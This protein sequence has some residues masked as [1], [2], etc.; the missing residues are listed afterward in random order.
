VERRAPAVAAG[1]ADNQGSE[2]D[3][4]AASF[5]V[6]VLSAFVSPATLHLAVT[7]EYL[8]APVLAVA[9][10]SET[11]SAQSI[12]TLRLDSGTTLQGLEGTG[13]NLRFGVTLSDGSQYVDMIP[14]LGR[15]RHRRAA[16]LVSMFSSQVGREC[17][18]AHW[19]CPD[20]P[21]PQTVTLSPR[22]SV[23]VFCQ[24]R[25]VGESGPSHRRH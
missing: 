24:H 2:L 22:W 8:T 4:A 6:G 20:W 15:R 12:T 9:V 14:W 16:G 5:S 23:A 11:V 3:A 21:I 17:R 25:C 19:L 10:Q 7:Y 18:R 13:S 1:C